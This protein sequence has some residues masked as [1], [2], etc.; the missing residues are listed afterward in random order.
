MVRVWA[1]E[2]G[3]DNGSPDGTAFTGT[4]MAWILLPPTNREPTS[5]RRVAETLKVREVPAVG[6]HG[7]T[8]TIAGQAQLE[9]SGRL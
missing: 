2:Y 6:Q 5:E 4:T 8:P 9:L 7:S 1:A 3:V